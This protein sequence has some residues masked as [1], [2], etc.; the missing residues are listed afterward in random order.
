MHILYHVYSIVSTAPLPRGHLQ[1]ICM[2]KKKRQLWKKFDMYMIGLYYIY[3]YIYIY[4]IIYIYI[5]IYI[6]YIYTIYI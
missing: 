4:H 3:I 2:L 1:T 5:Y 6:V